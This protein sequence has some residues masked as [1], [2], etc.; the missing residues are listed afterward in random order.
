MPP[1]A[2]SSEG[3]AARRI[4]SVRMSDFKTNE[5]AHLVDG[6]QFEPQ[7]ENPML[8]FRGASRYYSPRYR[9]RFALECR[10]IALRRNDIGFRNIIVIIPSR[11]TMDEADRVLEVLAGIGLKRGEDGSQIYVICEVPPNIILA[12]AFAQRFDGFSIGSNDLTQLTLGVDRDSAEPA[13]LFDE[14]N[15]AVKWMIAC[16]IASAR[17]GWASLWPSVAWRPRNRRARR[18]PAEDMGGA[19]VAAHRTAGPRDRVRP[20]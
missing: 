10:A 20:T 6:A 5:Y 19:A 2:I 7:E 15:D 12:G 9:D 13:G 14:R 8:G 1:N 18:R 16:V 3:E 17:R 11:R 4:L